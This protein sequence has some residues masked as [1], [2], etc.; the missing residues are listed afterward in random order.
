MIKDKS[1]LNMIA[2][3]D[4]VKLLVKVVMILFVL[5]IVVPSPY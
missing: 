2:D 3:E 1:Q 5:L 4:S